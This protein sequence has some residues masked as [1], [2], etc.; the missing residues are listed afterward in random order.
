VGTAN[1]DNRSFRL[2]FEVTALVVDQ[3]FAREMEEML[4]VDLERSV[5]FDAT[6]LGEM[7][8]HKRFAVRAAR[9]LSPIL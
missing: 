3:P 9:L 1:F 8:F 4:R 7:P 5:P 6:K 2:N